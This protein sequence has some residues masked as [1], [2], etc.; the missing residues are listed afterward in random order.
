MGIKNLSSL[1]QIYAPNSIKKI[2]FDDLNGK[3]IAIDA[4]LLIYSYVIAIRNTSEDLTNV[5]GEITSHIHAV[6]SKTLLYLDNGITPIFVFDGKPP[7]LKNDTLDKR[8]EVRETAKKLFLEENNEEKKI[9]LFKKSTIIT[10]KQMDQC[11]EILRAMGIPVVEA[12]EE[13]DSQCANLC[14]ENIAYGVG[15]E[16]M[17]ILTFGSNKLL[18]NISSS[19]K[20]EIIEYDLNKILNELN[21]TQQEFIDLCIL[22]GCDYVNHIDGI[23][24]K[25]AKDIIDEYR[26]IDNFLEK[27]NEIKN[28]KYEVDNDYINKVNKARNYFLNGPSIIYS[29]NQL[30]LGSLDQKK[31]KEL[32]I[33][34]Y[35]YS[36]I[37]VDKIIKKIIDA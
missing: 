1:I 22:L 26:S 19:K 20:N 7:V 2:H 31:I 33:N 30:K 3:K 15:S 13:S 35:S 8:K 29:N 18:R 17:D 4:S 28:K 37:K 5:D 32:L 16:D 27:S 25:R 11:K 6:V 12:P 36:K 34:K 21:Y 9:K 14:K 24:V 10:W 23:G